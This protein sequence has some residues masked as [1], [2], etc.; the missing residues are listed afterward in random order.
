MS[1]VHYQPGSF[2]PDERLDWAELV[3]LIGP[4]TAAIARYDGL[5]EAVPNPD[6]LLAPLGTQEAVLSSRIEG[7]Q[8]TAR[9]VLEYE[10][11]QEAPSSERRN[12]FVEVLNYRLAM[13]EAEQLLRKLPICLKVVRQTHRVLLRGARGKGRDPGEFRRLPNWIG[14]PD[15]TVEEARFVPIE[16]D[17]LMAGLDRWEKYLHEETRDQLVQLAVI[18]AEFE[19]LHP[20]LDGNGRLG[21]M[22]V[23]LYLAEKSLIRRPM[24]YIS[25]FLEA[26]R[27]AYYEGLLAVSR[28]DDWTGWCRFFLEALRT[29]AED[30]IA[31]ARRILSLYDR[32][33]HHVTDLTHSQYAI[34]SLDFIFESPAFSSTR[35]IAHEKVPA[36]AARRILNALR[37]DGV[38]RTVLP[39]SGRR[40]AIFVFDEL[41][42]V[43]EGRATE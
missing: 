2:P 29:Q 18:H 39:A 12:D 16:A 30:N 22:L 17:K 6:V 9:E 21:R 13:R 31:K 10:A 27:D 8:A 43:A 25:A 5:L 41:L 40:P 33:K 11:G 20:F 1:P 38:L 28:D 32:M 7:T 42:E 23:P 35:F 3:P 19:A 24:F 4:T 36:P 14:P 34:S 26:N 15:C 37:D